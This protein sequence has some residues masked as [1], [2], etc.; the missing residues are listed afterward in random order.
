MWHE[1]A[2][3]PFLNN[4]YFKSY[5]DFF[6]NKLKQNKV[7]VVYTIMPLWGEDSPDN[8]LKF[9]LN[10]NC[11]KKTVVNNFLNSYA[12]ENCEEIKK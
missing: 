3:Y 5:K 4:K 6:I 9:I 1:G 2:N 8:V 12:I 10:K 7:E 11:I